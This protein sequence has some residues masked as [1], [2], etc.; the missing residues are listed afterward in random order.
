MNYLE[1][2]LINIL[3]FIIFSE[4]IIFANYYNYLMEYFLWIMDIFVKK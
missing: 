4:R 3:I 2:F 1:L